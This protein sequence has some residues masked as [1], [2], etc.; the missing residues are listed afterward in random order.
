M[1]TEIFT[2]VAINTTSCIAV[3]VL[4]ME[5]EKSPLPKGDFRGI[6][7]PAKTSRVISF[8][9]RRRIKVGGS[10]AFNGS[11]GDGLRRR[12]Y[13]DLEQ[14]L[15]ETIFKLIT[16]RGNNSGDALLWYSLVKSTSRDWIKGTTTR[17]YLKSSECLHLF[18][19]Q[20]PLFL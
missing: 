20:Y 13:L 12:A 1:L 5:T 3:P 10:P 15:A 9:R 17:L 6:S 8:V 11:T 14:R 18:S 16:E 19:R 4:L 7:S 2:N